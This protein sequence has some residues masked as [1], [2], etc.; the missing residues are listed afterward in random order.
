MLAILQEGVFLVL[1]AFMGADSGPVALAYSCL[2]CL[3]CMVMW[4]VLQTPAI[5]HAAAD[6]Y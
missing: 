6:V 1:T 4:V 5:M 3:S 2:L